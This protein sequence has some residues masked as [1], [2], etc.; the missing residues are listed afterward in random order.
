M[1]TIERV[2]RALRDVLDPEVGV[3]VVDLGLVYGL[4]IDGTAVRVR[5]A[6][7]TPT[8][9]LS[10]HLAAAAE[11]AIARHVPGVRPVVEIAL[12]PPWT[13]AMMSDDA[14]RRLGWKT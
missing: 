11:R 5:L 4:T 12:D 6:M 1:P 8:C 2:L 7:T 9:P 10:E 14:R 3:N 13:P